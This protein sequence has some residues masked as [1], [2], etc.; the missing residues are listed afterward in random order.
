MYLP[1]NGRIAIIDNEIKEVR[2]LF[3]IFSKNRIPFTYIDGSDKDWLPDEDNELNDLRLIFLDLNLTG[4]RTPSDKEIRSTLYPI[5]KRVISPN[6]FPYSIILWSKQEAEYKSV[7]EDLFINDLND[8][9]P[10][11]IESFIKSDFFDLDSE[12]EKVSEKNIIDEIKKIFQSHQAYS[13]L[14]YWEN[15][16][17]KSADITLQNI[18]TAYDETWANKS[19]FVI[20]KLGQAYL[21]VKTHKESSYISKIKGALQAF[22]S[23]FNDTLEYNLNICSNLHEQDHL[24]YD[25]TSLNREELLDMINQKLLISKAHIDNNHLDYTGM[26]TVDEN[27][28]SNKIFETLFNESF[29]RFAL[30]T[31]RIDDYENLTTA[32]Q[33]SKLKSLASEKRKE[34]R[35]NWEKI[36]VVVTPLC[37][38]VQNKQKNVRVIKGFIIDKKYKEYI[39]NKSE[40]IYISPSFYD[41]ELKVS[42]IIVL[43]FRYFFTF[44]GDL[45]KI[46]GLT[47]KMRLRNEVISEIQSKIARHVS[48]QGILYVE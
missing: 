29:D 30:N 40:A 6:N 37:D 31:S 21:G 20:D 25:E 8:R 38:K 42:R 16:V 2:P 23:L 11:S 41:S 27:T 45:S 14:V 12:Q 7:V 9:Q 5:L 17:H 10:I 36:Y 46:K 19:N 44:S 13:T 47:P 35:E 48:R 28:K 18:F 34:M 24:R 3:K 32:K 39:D 43:N 33:I 15:K 1:I 26:I 22:N 4:G